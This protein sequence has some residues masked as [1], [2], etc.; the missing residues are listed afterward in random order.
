MIV[1]MIVIPIGLNKACF[2]YVGML[3]GK[4]NEESIMHYYNVAM[5]MTCVIGAIKLALLYALR[6]S[7]LQIFADDVDLG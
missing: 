4:D 3:L 2:F 6:N 7:I 1:L 5:A